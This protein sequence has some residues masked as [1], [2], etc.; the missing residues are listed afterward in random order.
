MLYNK[1]VRPS[2]SKIADSFRL[3]LYIVSKK[4]AVQ[5]SLL[6]IR[7]PTCYTVRDLKWNMGTWVV[8]KVSAYIQ[9]CAS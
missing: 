1:E 8:I 5:S 2:H 4:I 7:V 6:F 9:I 3:S